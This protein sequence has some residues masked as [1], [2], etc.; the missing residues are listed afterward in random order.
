MEEL[1][2]HKSDKVSFDIMYL[3]FQHGEPEMTVKPYCKTVIMGE[4]KPDSD[5]K[6]NVAEFLEARVKESTIFPKFVKSDSLTIDEMNRKFHARVH[7]YS[8]YI[9]TDG[10]FGAVNTIVMNKNTNDTYNGG[11]DMLD[12]IKVVINEH[13]ADDTLFLIHNS[14]DAHN[15]GYKYFYHT[16]ND[17]KMFDAIVELGWFPEK[18]TAKLVIY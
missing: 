16:D 14:K 18:Q 9:A 12:D 3:D 7:M 13:V 15:P 2:T 11:N 10:R 5:P 17:G 6:K 8:N 4:V 1:T